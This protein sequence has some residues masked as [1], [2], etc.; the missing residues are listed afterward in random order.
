MMGEASTKA[1]LNQTSSLSF[2]LYNARR[3]VQVRGK[4]V[5]VVMVMVD[6]GRTPS[7]C[8]PPA[9]CLAG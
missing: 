1:V 5:V 8:T 3:E 2:L 6:A 4:L 9:R 7:S